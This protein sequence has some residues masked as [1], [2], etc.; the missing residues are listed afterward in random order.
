MSKELEGSLSFRKFARAT[1]A[2]F[3]K[4][5]RKDEQIP[6]QDIEVQWCSHVFSRETDTLKGHDLGASPFRRGCE[7]VFGGRSP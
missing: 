7:M 2:I 3:A 1:A 6:Q 4:L 5:Y